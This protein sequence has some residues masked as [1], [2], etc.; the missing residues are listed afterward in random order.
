M[1]WSTAVFMAAT[2]TAAPAGEEVELVSHSVYFTLKEPTKENID[3]VIASC[4][5]YS[6]RYE[7]RIFFACGER[8][9]ATGPYK[10]KDFHVTQT[11]IFRG[12]DALEKYMKGEARQQF[13]AECKP[14]WSKVRVFETNLR[15]L[16][17][18]E[19]K[20]SESNGK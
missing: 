1:V 7:G 13:V 6:S 14:F 2:L 4:R 20:K 17:M 8:A 5:K 11:L 10:D 15:G 9:S 12:R 19:P 3:R 18:P 16:E